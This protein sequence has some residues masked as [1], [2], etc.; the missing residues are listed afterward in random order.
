MK[1]EALTL[2]GAIVLIIENLDGEFKRGIVEPILP[3]MEGWTR[4]RR[5][6]WI[7]TNN[8]RMR[9]I[10]KLLNEKGL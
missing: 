7:R 4:K 5:E 1:Y 6:S 9:A 2:R 8:K 10:C 3:E